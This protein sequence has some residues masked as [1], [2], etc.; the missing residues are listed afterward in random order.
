MVRGTE[1]YHCST[2]INPGSFALNAPE[3]PIII[4]DNQVIALVPTIRCENGV[5]ELYESGD[6]SSFADL[7]YSVG[8]TFTFPKQSHL[9]L[10]YNS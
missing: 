1:P 9:L 7:S 2:F 10:L 6:N 5:T 4:L 8:I 3:L